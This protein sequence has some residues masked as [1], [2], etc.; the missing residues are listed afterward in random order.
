MADIKTPRREHAAQR[1]QQR[2]RI[3]RWDTSITT[4]LYFILIL[5]VILLLEGFALEFVAPIAV[6][7]LGL[8]WLAGW[9]QS[10][11][12]YRQFLEDEMEKADREEELE[13][14]KE[15]Y[16]ARKVEEP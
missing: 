6:A 14:I 16:Q 12:L 2:A 4:F 5:V 10:K 13:I 9:R 1:A 15:H 11:Q 8:F 7:G 3:A